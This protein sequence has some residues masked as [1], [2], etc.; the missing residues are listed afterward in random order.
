[1][2]DGVVGGVTPLGAAPDE[3]V[4]PVLPLGGLLMG[5]EDEPGVVA[6]SV[7]LPQ[8]PNA[9]AAAIASA[10]TA[11]EIHTKRLMLN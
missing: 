8:A 5:A 6:E 10:V 1:M 9:S 2:L 11:M 3:P 7:F 4:D